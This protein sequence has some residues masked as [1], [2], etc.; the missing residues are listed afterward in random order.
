MCMY[1]LYVI[2]SDVTNCV[3]K[4]LVAEYMY[5]VVEICIQIFH[6]I[7]K[8][9]INKFDRILTTVH[10]MT[11]LFVPFCS[12]QV[13][14]STDVNCECFAK[15]AKIGQNGQSIVRGFHQFWV[16]FC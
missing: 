2:E 12:A 8:Y 7:Q 14:E 9:S 4:C 5:F 6:L 10:A 16:I 3:V 13:D 15:M 11:K 1:V